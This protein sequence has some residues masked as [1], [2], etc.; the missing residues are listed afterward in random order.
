[1]LKKPDWLLKLKQLEL[2][3]KQD[4]PL[5]HKLQKKPKKKQQLLKLHKRQKPRDWLLKS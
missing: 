3:K 5:R 4:L 2:Q 1:M